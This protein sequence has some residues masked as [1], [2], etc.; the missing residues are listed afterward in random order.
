MI[1]SIKSVKTGLIYSLNSDILIFLNEFS[2]NKIYLSEI[3]N[4]DTPLEDLAVLPFYWELVV[5]CYSGSCISKRDKYIYDLIRGRE[6]LYNIRKVTWM[7][8]VDAPLSDLLYGS[9]GVKSLKRLKF[10]EKFNQPL[11]HTLQGLTS[12][13]NLTFGVGFNQPLGDSL[14]GLTNLTHLTF[15]DKFNQPLGDSLQGLTNLTHLKF[16]RYFNQPLGDSLR[17]LSNL[18]HLESGNGQSSKNRHL[19]TEFSIQ[20]LT[21]LV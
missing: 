18:I 15:G 19:G 20:G 8:G 9:L 6:Y 2:T 21:S 4:K 14:Q 17:G 5:D 12:L 10:G 13:T 1:I 3:I 16:G 11:G 7:S